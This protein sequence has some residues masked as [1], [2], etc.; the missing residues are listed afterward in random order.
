MPPEQYFEQIDL[1]QD[2]EAHTYRKH[3]TVQVEFASAPGVIASRE[4]PNHYEVGAA[5]VTGSTGD[6]WS[7]SRER[8][9]A[10]Y[11]PVPPL[12]SGAP[13]S[14]RNKPLPVLAKQMPQDFSVPRSLQ[15]DRLRGRAGD[16]LMQYAPGDWGIVEGAKF[17][18]VYRLVK[19]P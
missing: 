2:C 16:W 12:A 17:R 18:Q 6:R 4:G 11:E 7:V 14:Y 19:D 10:R 13:G 9:D 15:G 8:F 1:G 5:L 3:E